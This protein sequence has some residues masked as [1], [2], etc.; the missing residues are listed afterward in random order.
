MMP[1]SSACGSLSVRVAPNN[2]WRDVKLS[3]TKNRAL[4]GILTADITY[5]GKIYKDIPKQW[6]M[7]EN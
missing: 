6:F 4:K 3:G 5:N 7:I 1:L 2:Q